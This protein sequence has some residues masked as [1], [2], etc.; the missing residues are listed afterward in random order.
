MT[1]LT[2][3]SDFTQSFP[4]FAD[5]SAQ[6]LR[7]FI[8][9]SLQFTFARPGGIKVTRQAGAVDPQGV[10]LTVAAVMGLKPGKQ[11]IK[12]PFQA[13][14]RLF[15]PLEGAVHFPCLIRCLVHPAV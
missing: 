12:P 15:Q 5:C 7:R 14:D 6:G 4:D 8:G 13:I 11:T 3:N 9:E 10:S 2:P 1:T